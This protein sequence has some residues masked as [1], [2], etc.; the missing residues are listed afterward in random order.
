M[1]SVVTQTLS[2]KL[3]LLPLVIVLATMGL[4]GVA[5]IVAPL[6]LVIPDAVYVV[7]LV[8]T[9]FM[10]VTPIAFA[11][12]IVPARFQAVLWLNPLTYLV[13]AYRSVLVDRVTLGL[14]PF[15]IFTI[16]VIVVFAA[17]ATL[18]ARYKDIVVDF[19]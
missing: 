12:E 10:F 11:P 3:L 14:L 2:A 17:G 9:L 5:W 8:T 19:E 18:C 4:F 1:L 15:G 13:E 7:N 6:G 16:G